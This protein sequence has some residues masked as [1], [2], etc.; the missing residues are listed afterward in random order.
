MT[1]FIINGTISL[2]SINQNK[3]ARICW[4][5]I[6]I[7]HRILFISILIILF[8]F[9]WSKTIADIWILLHTSLAYHLIANHIFIKLPT[10]TIITFRALFTT[11]AGHESFVS[12]LVVYYSFSQPFKKYTA[13]NPRIFVC[14]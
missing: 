1:F 7:S 11:D 6:M 8:F 12:C 13:K 5:N 3:K 4:L 14:L 2:R 10:L 9:V